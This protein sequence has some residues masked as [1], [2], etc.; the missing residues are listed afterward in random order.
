MHI[1]DPATFKIVR[2]ALQRANYTEQ[3]VCERLAIASIGSARS[4]ARQ[5]SEWKLN[6]A[7]DVCIRLFLDGAFVPAVQIVSLLTEPALQ[8]M[9]EL[10]L[11]RCREDDASQLAATV[12]LG[13]TQGIYVAS[14][15]ESNPDL[16]PFALPPD[17]VYPAIGKNT[18]RFL[19]LL[20]D[21]Q[22]EAFLELC[23]GA[24]AAALIA[25]ARGARQAFTFDITPR[26][27]DFAEFNRLLNGLENVT[28]AC[29]DLYEPAGGRTF[30]FIAAHP[31]YVPATG[32]GLIYKEGGEDGESII[33]RII[34]GLPV[35]LRPGGQFHCLC[36]GSDRSQGAF[37]D[38]IRTWLGSAAGEFDIVLASEGV[39][40][41]HTLKRWEILTAR[42]KITGMFYGSVIIRRHATARP[43]F[44]LRR[45]RE[46]GAS[47][48]GTE[49]LFQAAAQLH[50]MSALEV[51]NLYPRIAD[52]VELQVQHKWSKGEFH[53]R[54]L[55]LRIRNP[56]PR[57]VQA[58]VWVVKF[59]EAS[60]GSRTG[61]QIAKSLLDAGVINEAPAQVIA[62]MMCTMI[63][64][65][66]LTVT[67]LPEAG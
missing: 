16:T 49:W 42:F 52:E 34:E 37:E 22:P 9:Q 47:F 11:L 64:E 8:G 30:D 41:P 7:L 56:F 13:P 29:G 40:T 61:S 6:D 2:D 54:S 39:V 25:A 50:S 17:T 10:G 19:S 18:Q 63:L 57:Q 67:T 51:M 27:T 59:L 48:A 5:V 33:R 43:C 66:F 28:A 20:P 46:E 62:G 24:G 38:R 4:L 15:R 32:D 21:V 3:A 60:D 44:T 12:Q 31:P 53:V 45:M 14:D 58:E 65:G 23:G 36:A 55:E 26:S 1:G 35:Y